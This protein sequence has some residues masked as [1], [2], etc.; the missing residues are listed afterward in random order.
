MITYAFY[1]LCHA[2]NWTPNYCEHFSHCL[3]LSHYSAEDH[4][5]QRDRENEGEGERER[6]RKRKR[7]RERER[8]MDRQRIWVEE[9]ERKRERLIDL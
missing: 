9:G 1:K 3:I 5:L 6:R 8:Q 4:S 7:E 2:Y